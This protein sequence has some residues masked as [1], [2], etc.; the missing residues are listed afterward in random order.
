MSDFYIKYNDVLPVVQAYL[1]D[2]NGYVD[3]TSATV[4]FVYQDRKQLNQAV[5][6]STSILSPISGLVEYTWSSGVAIGSYIAEWRVNFS[7][8]KQM[9]FPNSTILTFDIVD[10]VG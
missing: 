8:G 2:T 4:K 9:S 5:T 7:N 1:S 3:L 10:N 6:G